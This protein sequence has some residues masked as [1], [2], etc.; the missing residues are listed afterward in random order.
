MKYDQ[1]AREELAK[2]KRCEMYEK[3]LKHYEKLEEELL[4][5]KHRNEC[6][7]RQIAHVQELEKHLIEKQLECEQIE[8]EREDLRKQLKQLNDYIAHEEANSRQLKNDYFLLKQ[9]YSDEQWNELTKKLT[10]ATDLTR[11]IQLKLK[12]KQEESENLKKNLSQHQSTIEKLENE[13]KIE[14]QLREEFQEKYLQES[15]TID[16]NET[17]RKD[18]EIAEMQQRLVRERERR[19]PLVAPIESN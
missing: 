3:N 16:F 14:R 12:K 19:F 17:N 11:Q 15:S 6:Y 5:L 18:N 8:K 1:L 10:E 4:E 7:S 13:L 2:E 9:R